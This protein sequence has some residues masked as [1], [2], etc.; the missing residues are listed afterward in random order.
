MSFELIHTSVEKSLRGGAGFATAVATEGMPPGLENVLAE[1]SAFEVDSARSSGADEVDWCHRIVTLQGRSYTVL[2]RVSGCGPDWS[3]RPNRVAHHLVLDASERP[4]A[5]PAWALANFG[6]FSSG[7]P[8]VEWRK[9]GPRIPAGSLGPRVP[10][11]WAAAGFDPGWAGMVASALLDGGGATVYLVL[12]GG[13]GTLSLVEDVF[14]IL[15]HDRRWNM[16]FS[17]RFQRVPVST[18]CQLRCVRAGAPGVASLLAEPGCR[19]IVV[20]PGTSAGEGPAAEAARSGREV[21]P[22]TRTPSTRIEPVK[23]ATPVHLEPVSANQVP[24]AKPTRATVPAPAGPDLASIAR[25]SRSI[26]RTEVGILPG[27]G[28]FQRIRTVPPIDLVLFGIAI[29]EVAAAIVLMVL[30]PMR[31]R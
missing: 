16:T 28:L 14:A 6:E 12:P 3:G 19:K 1:M 7:V 22:A 23:L 18:R 30:L 5:G 2:S 15:P 21:A 29:V 31:F 4:E 11:H 9:T 8:E 10:S 17:T 24:A 25:E 13:R 26:G 20:T 27:T